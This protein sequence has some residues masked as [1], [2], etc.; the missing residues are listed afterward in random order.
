[1]IDNAQKIDWL[2]QIIIYEGAETCETADHWL[3]TVAGSIAVSLILSVL[4][5][6]L[7]P[8][9]MR[10]VLKPAW[11]KIKALICCGKRASPPITD[12]KEIDILSL[13]EEY[14]LKANSI[15]ASLG[16]ELLSIFLTIFVIRRFGVGAYM[17]GENLMWDMFLL[18]AIRPRVAPFTGL[19]G[20]FKGWSQ[21]A[22]GD[23]VTDSLLSIVAGTSIAWN[24]FHYTWTTNPNPS[25]PDH[26]LKILG[27]GAIMTC[28]PM[29]L[30]WIGACVMAWKKFNIK[31]GD[32]IFWAIYGALLLGF[33]VA[34]KIFLIVLAMP[35]IA[36]WELFC[37]LLIAIKGRKNSSRSTRSR[38]ALHYLKDPLRADAAGFRPS[39]G[40]LVFFSWVVNVGNWLFFASYL[41]LEGDAYCP[42]GSMALS[43]IWILAPLAVKW[44]VQ[45]LGL[46]VKKK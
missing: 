15:M 42:S 21:A 9:V 33:G 41:I 14:I 39:Y 22:L 12:E 4:Q 10:K 11:R 16:G 45:A 23:L 38:D 25:A 8:W 37:A 35:L 20:F 32:G 3:L 7:G 44:P 24:Y 5:A 6:A 40:V 1:V 19:L 36:I 28:V 13:E 17:N 29:A 34:I 27:V 18:F 26:T 2:G 46:Y 43:A 31:A 30:G